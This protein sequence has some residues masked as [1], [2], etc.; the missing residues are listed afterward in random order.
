MAIIRLSENTINL[1][2]AGEV[3][4]RPSSV[5]KELVENSIDAGAQHIEIYLEQAGKN[6]IVVEDDG[7]GMSPDD[8]HLAIQR[9]TTSKLDE[10]DIL[11][12]RS[13][14][15]RG[16][17][18]P[19]IAS[20]SKFSITSKVK[21]A[22]SAFK[23]SVV[24]ETV[25]ICE[26]VH[27]G[28]T[29]IEVRDLF[30]SIPARLKFL[31]TNSTELSNCIDVVKKLALSNPQIAFTLRHEDK[32]VLK[33]AKSDSL[34]F[35]IEEMLGKD[36]AQ[37]SLEVDLSSQY[38]KVYGYV[39]VPTHHRASS[40]EQF[41]FVN[42]RPVKDKLI[43]GCIKAAYQDYV[44]QGR[45]PPLVLFIEVPF[46]FVDVNVHPAK[47]EVRFQDGAQIRGNIINAIKKI[48]GAE[49]SAV[50]TTFSDKAMDYFTAPK[51]A[52]PPRSERYGSFGDGSSD[53]RAQGVFTPNFSTQNTEKLDTQT[54]LDVKTEPQTHMSAQQDN[55]DAE[56]EYLNVFE[57]GSACAQLHNNYIIAQSAKGIIMVD[58]HAAHE[59]VVYEQL[60]AQLETTPL[61]S[62]PLLLPVIV[63]LTSARKADGLIASKNHLAGLALV[64][65]KLD[66]T[67]IVVKE[68]PGI[69]IKNDITRLILDIADE[70][71][72]SEQ[73]FSLSRL[74]EHVVETYACHHSIRS[75]QKLSFAEMN[76]LLRQIESTP[77]G[78]QCCH[79]RP[80]YVSL[81]LSDLEKLF[82]RK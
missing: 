16:E 48:I 43:S 37:N 63:E 76:A 39:S 46:H 23:L 34:K 81:T 4:E 79:G 32:T 38:S 51:F 42:N 26:V 36:F 77:G 55:Q 22:S 61:K 56:Q 6:L 14:G 29:K 44:V 8:M 70:I 45:F 57:L 72:D 7:S 19:S 62:Q 82:C 41:T 12:I 1:I 74:I 3:V 78:G 9:H 15:F 80:T 11:N 17:A 10:S 2:S 28:G 53:Y 69:L 31:K 67:K 54:K 60:K 58:Q 24:D 13:F 52:T 47:S 73:E 18:L 64:I 65:E 20:V 40:D 27:P 25:S 5:V 50:S 75:G 33:L 66:E 68:V 35:R 49:N 21:G 71:S 30:Y 59:R